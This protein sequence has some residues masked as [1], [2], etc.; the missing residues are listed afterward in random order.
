V[1]SESAILGWMLAVPAAGGILIFALPLKHLRIARTLAMAF[2]GA[3]FVLGCVAAAQMDW[4]RGDLQLALHVPHLHLAGATF[5]LAADGLSMPLALLAAGI[6]MMACWG[7]YA[8]GRSLRAYFALLLWL[9][10]ALLGLFLAQ[11]LLL[12]TIFSELLMV[13]LYFLIGI[14]GSGRK[15][16]AASKFLLF[17]LTSA[18]LMVAALLA[19]FQATRGLGEAGGS[20]WDLHELS[21]NAAF[22]ARL[23]T[24]FGAA[25]FWLLL[26][27][28]GIKMAVVPLHTWLSDVVAEAP[29]PVAMLTMAVVTKVGAYGLL[30]IALP[31]FGKPGEAPAGWF[32][33]AAMGIVTLLYGA[34]GALAQK[35]LRRVIAFASIAQMGYVL[36]GIGVGTAV[37]I[38]GATFQILAQAMTMGMLIFIAGMIIDRT[39]HS[40]IKRLGG[41]GGHM[42]VFA[43]WSAVGFLAAMGLPGLCGFVGELL[44]LL[45]TFANGQRGPLSRAMAL[46]LLGAAA[47]VLLGACF[48]WTYQR[49]FLGPAKPE[50]SNVARM[51]STEK[52]MLAVFA[53]AQLVL[54]ILPGIALEPMR[55]TLEAW[56][57]G[58]G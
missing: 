1:A 13:P 11:D 48:I 52:W 44:V 12:F 18:A 21:I 56:V 4:T 17:W 57:R 22:A 41:L 2:L 27:A 37:G 55:A 40:D 45:G 10:T 32:L 58:I 25:A 14:W 46:G 38:A 36:L 53:I 54:G 39:G 47:M 43:G 20:L 7:S 50:H 30:R 34:L 35:D 42:P 6:G 15:E 16:Y 26:L 9:I 33:L 5:S 31:L 24:G 49:V 8:I 28:L 51:S 29:I 23:Q 19:I 3:T